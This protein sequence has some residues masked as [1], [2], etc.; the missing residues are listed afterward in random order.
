MNIVVYSTPTCPYCYQVKD[1]LS[2]RGV[3][4]T[5]Y[6]VSTNRTAASEMVRKSGQAGV[7]VITVG[8]Q[9][10]VGFD[11]FRLEQL[12]ASRNNGQ[13]PRFGLQVADANKVA[14]K[15]RLTPVSGAFVGRVTPASPGERA[16]IRKGD[17]ITMINSQ[18]IR[19]ADDLGNAL[20]TLGKG[21]QAVIT[22]LRGERT[23]KSEV[24]I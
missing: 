22:I 3:K 8:D 4:F 16:G 11:R 9:V 12:L 13:H 6:D 5:E 15:E 2:Q 7:P 19:N 21:N 18:S 23:L 17:I 10:I 20:S 1:F 14:R 24:V